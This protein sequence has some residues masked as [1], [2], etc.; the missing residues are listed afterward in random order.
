MKE[1]MAQLRHMI[2][3]GQ[4]IRLQFKIGKL[5]IRNGDVSWKTMKDED[6]N[7]SQPRHAATSKS[8]LAY[9]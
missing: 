3:L 8:F 2:K 1:I 9:F 5:I 7:K 4:N 6:K